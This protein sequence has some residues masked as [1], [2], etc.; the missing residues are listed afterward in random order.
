MSFCAVETML[1]EMQR[2]KVYVEEAGVRQEKLDLAT[3][4]LSDNIQKLKDKIQEARQ[5]ANSV[6]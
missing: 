2:F 3:Q 6:S 5:Q 1:D 4:G